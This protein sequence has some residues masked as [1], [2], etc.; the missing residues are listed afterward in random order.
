MSFTQTQRPAT[1]TEVLEA[2]VALLRD[3][4]ADF[5]AEAIYWTETPT[6]DPSNNLT[7]FIQVHAGS[8]SFDQ[9]IL[10][11]GTI[12]VEHANVAVTIFHRSETD[13]TGRSE[14]SLFAD[15]EGLLSMKKRV[16]RALQHKMLYDGD[17]VQIAIANVRPVQATEPFTGDGDRPLDSLSITYGVS[18]EWDLS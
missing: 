6:P 7:L 13:Q 8:G 17:G 5:P 2:F 1:Q 14:A 16:L 3:E 11:S 10:A 12:T 15:G 9:G 18:F 4:F